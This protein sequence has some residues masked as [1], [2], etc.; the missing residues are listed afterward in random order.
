MAVVSVN[1]TL[2]WPSCN[3][4]CLYKTVRAS[5]FH[6]LY[7]LQA[8]PLICPLFTLLAPLNTCLDVAKEVRRWHGNLGS[9]RLG[10]V[11]PDWVPK[12]RQWNAK[13]QIHFKWASKRTSLTFIYYQGPRVKSSKLAVRVLIHKPTSNRKHLPPKPRSF[14]HSQRLSNCVN[15]AG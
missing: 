9:H 2:H 3:A 1:M 5:T 11:V 8:A 12:L 4:F 15:D 13:A 6:V 10:V 7:S 14:S